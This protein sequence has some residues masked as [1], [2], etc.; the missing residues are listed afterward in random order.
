MAKKIGN[1]E[2]FVIGPHLPTAPGAFLNRTPQK[3]LISK[4]IEPLVLDMQRWY[5][6]LTLSKN[7][8]IY[9]LESCIRITLNFFNFL[10]FV[11]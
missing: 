4:E 9:D 11:I 5:S 3:I 6:Y 2:F 1:P 10:L 7:K 8:D